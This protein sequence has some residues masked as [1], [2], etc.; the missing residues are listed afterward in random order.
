MRRTAPLPYF[1]KGYAMPSNTPAYQYLT[2]DERLAQA[3]LTTATL[4]DMVLGEDALD[5]SDETL[6]RAV[7]LLLRVAAA[8]RAD[9]DPT[10]RVKEA[11]A[12]FD[13]NS[14]AHSGKTKVNG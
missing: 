10:A 11:L 4:C 7:G 6:I 12:R 13:E 2:R 9:T 14:A 5:R 8:A 3:E 1:G